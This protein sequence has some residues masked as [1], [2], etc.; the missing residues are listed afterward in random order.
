MRIGCVV[1]GQGDAAALPVL[2]RRLRPGL[3]I[4]MPVRLAR[5]R[6]AVE[7][8]LRRAVTLASLNAG[9]GSPVLLLADADDDCPV[10]LSAKIMEWSADEIGWTGCRIAVV[11][12]VCEFEAWFLAAAHSLAGVRGLPFDLEP[13]VDAEAVRGAKG[14]LTRQ[15][16][17]GRSY[18]ETVD[19]PALAA[20]FDLEAAA[21]CR[22]FQKFLKDLDWLVSDP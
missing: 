9:S 5:G 6:F 19:Q 10:E 1:E 11:L 22:S 21:S 14:W 7:T 12:P 13:P 18:K 17:P 4:P 2:L 20:Q 15:L 8:E 16:P 3:Q